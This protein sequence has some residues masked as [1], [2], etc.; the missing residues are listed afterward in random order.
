M[1]NHRSLAPPD[2]HEHARTSSLGFGFVADT[3]DQR[4]VDCNCIVWLNSTI[5]CSHLPI[6]P[7]DHE[8]KTIEMVAVKPRPPSLRQRNANLVT[9]SHRLHGGG[10]FDKS[11]HGGGCDEL[12]HLSME[13][14][15]W[16]YRIGDVYLS[17]MVGLEI[18]RSLGE[19]G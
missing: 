18:F 5:L 15:C 3:Q 13:W 8:L 6:E 1:Y 4:P 11:R 7:R 14:K 12:I 17:T 19:R 16:E 9:Y 2:G 10:S